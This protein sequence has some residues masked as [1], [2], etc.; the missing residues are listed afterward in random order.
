[1]ERWGPSPP[2]GN[3]LEIGNT[4]RVQLDD[5]VLFVDT[6][7]SLRTNLPVVHLGSS[8]RSHRWGDD[9]D[10]GS[11]GRG[12]DGVE[13]AQEDMVM[14]GDALEDREFGRV[15]AEEE[16]LGR[17]RSDVDSTS[18]NTPLKR[19]FPQEFHANDLVVVVTVDP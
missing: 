9:P 14:E 17:V 5:R 16:F 6:S 11:G 13:G 4:R 19:S 7:S 8:V 12:S 2:P 1:M 3:R 18:Q 15:R 10:V